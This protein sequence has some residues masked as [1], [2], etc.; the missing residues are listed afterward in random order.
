MCAG[1]ICLRSGKRSDKGEEMRRENIKYVV[2]GIGLGFLIA[3]GLF[4]R[5]GGREK[6]VLSERE[7]VE[8]ARNLGMIFLTEG[9][10]LPTKELGEPQE[11][12]TEPQPAEN[13][14]EPDAER[15][16]EEQDPAD[17]G[18]TGQDLPDEQKE[19]LNSGDKKTSEKEIESSQAADLAKPEKPTPLAKPQE[20]VPPKQPEKPKTTPVKPAVDVITEVVS[21]DDPAAKDLLPTPNPN[22][23]KST[24]TL[25]TNHF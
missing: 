24:E 23:P 12:G 10:D 17:K 8:R 25:P 22:R 5:F 7:I 6:E 11:L 20:I 14:T 9:T 16:V 13:L 3:A 4:L 21:G 18:K 2:L 1:R 15:T 19:E